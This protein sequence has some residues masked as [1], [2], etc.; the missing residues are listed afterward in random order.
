MDFAFE[1]IVHGTTSR[2]CESFASPM[3]KAPRLKSKSDAKKVSGIVVMPGELAT[4]AALSPQIHDVTWRR[5]LFDPTASTDV[6]A[7]SETIDSVFD[8]MAK[9]GPTAIDLR[10]VAV[11]N[12]SAEHLVAV[13]RATYLDRETVPGWPYALAQA[14]DALR[15]FELDPNEV[16]VGLV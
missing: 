11:D 4:A 10:G 6:D 8:A 3:P 1:D 7:I 13:L 16:L 5:F 12:V 9:V 14:P 15:R 2:T